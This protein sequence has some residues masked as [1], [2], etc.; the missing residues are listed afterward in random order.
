M[1]SFY[2]N[3]KI[4]LY[5]GTYAN[6]RWTD[7]ITVKSMTQ[8]RLRTRT[9]RSSIKIIINQSVLCWY[10][11]GLELV[12]RCTVFIVEQWTSLANPENYLGKA[13]FFAK[14]FFQLLPNSSINSKS[15]AKNCIADR[16]IWLSQIWIIN[17]GLIKINRMR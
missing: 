8:D 6:S 1:L 3:R 12:V 10:E 4:A 15:I 5:V 16:R 11:N 13:K 14:I 2:E 17:K 7:S 9:N